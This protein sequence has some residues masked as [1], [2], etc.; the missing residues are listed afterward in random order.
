MSLPNNQNEDRSTI[1]RRSDG[2]AQEYWSQVITP[3]PISEELRELI[4]EDLQ[5]AWHWERLESFRFR[6]K[7]NWGIPVDS[8]FVLLNDENGTVTRDQLLLF[9]NKMTAFYWLQTGQLVNAFGERNHMPRVVF[10]TIYREW[11]QY[12]DSQP[13]IEFGHYIANP[14]RITS[15]G[16]ST[17]PGVLKAHYS[18]CMQACDLMAKL[19]QE[20]E[21]GSNPLRT[22]LWRY[23]IHPLYKA[24]MLLIDRFEIDFQSDAD[25]LFRLED[26]AQQQTVL[27]VRTGLEASLSA[28][29]SFDSLR[30]ES[31]PLDR[32]DVDGHPMIDIVRTSLTTAVRFVLDLERREAIA[33]PESVQDGA[34]D[35]S[36]NPGPHL[37]AVD[38]RAGRDPKTWADSLIEAAEKHGYDDDH[39]TRVSIRR[40]QA[41]MVGEN[42][43]ELTPIPFGNRWKE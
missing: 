14:I 30:A 10:A 40:V 3:E 27:I 22:D 43:Y 9:C 28:P 12:F 20:N 18:L 35:P 32:S 34:L 42:Y 24:I 36:L 1:F 16:P 26:G 5:K 33:S 15:N 6:I 37:R 19:R 31:L 13:N 23:N 11:A 4:R 29:I 7:Y 41:A 21:L 25:N 2:D 39:T 17:I 38:G 8:Q